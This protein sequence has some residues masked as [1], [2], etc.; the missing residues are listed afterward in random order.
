MKEAS[1]QT[2]KTKLCSAP[3]LALP[4]GAENFIDYCDVSHKGLGAAL[5]QNEKERADIKKQYEVRALVMTIGLDL[6]KQI[7][8]AQTVAQKPKNLKN[9]D[10]G[11]KDLPNERLEPRL[12]I[13]IKDH[14]DVGTNP[15]NLDLRG[16]EYLLNHLYRD[17]RF[18]ITFFGDHFIKALGTSFDMSTLAYHPKQME[19][20][21]ENLPHTRE[22]ML[23]ACVID[24]GNGWIKHL[25]L[26]EF[27][28]NNSY[29]ASIKAAPFEALYGQKC[30]SPV[31]WAEVGEAQLIGPYLIQETTKKII[32]IKQR[33]QAARDR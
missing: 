2:L 18:R 31:C 15:R 9:E 7:L 20:S 24:F 11:G 30:S 33:I 19:Q 6:P 22:D 10:V 25:P 26:V 3:I 28:Y 5:M 1:F 4:Q 16:M 13:N 21:E 29:H 17:P 32:Q 14:R 8:N 12:K 27:S 23:R